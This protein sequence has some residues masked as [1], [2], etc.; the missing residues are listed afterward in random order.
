MAEGVSSGTG[1]GCPNG[2]DEYGNWPCDPVVV[3]YEGRDPDAEC[4][5]CGRVARWTDPDWVAHVN[6]MHDARSY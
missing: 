5:V 6:S 2:P 1:S 3:D 4:L